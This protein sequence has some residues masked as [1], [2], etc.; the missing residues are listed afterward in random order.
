MWNILLNRKIVFNQIHLKS[1]IH[2]LRVVFQFMDG[3]FNHDES[4]FKP[5]CSTATSEMRCFLLWTEAS[6][7]H[8]HWWSRSAVSD[9]LIWLSE[10]NC[11]FIPR[12]CREF[13]LFG[14]FTDRWKK[15]GTSFFFYF[16]YIYIKKKMFSF[17]VV[18]FFLIDQLDNS[19]FLIDQGKK[20]GF[21]TNLYYFKDCNTTTTM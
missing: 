18:F 2:N 19:P 15:V 10:T 7:R 9:F 6:C 8:P 16:L 3:L 21:S 17:K 11:V 20:R 4:C 14:V 12:L 1:F 5:S 13:I